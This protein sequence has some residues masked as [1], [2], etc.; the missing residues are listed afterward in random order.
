MAASSTRSIAQNPFLAAAPAD[1]STGGSYAMVQAGPAVDPAEVET[2]ELAVEILVKWSDTVLHVSHMS[3]ARSFTVG[4][5]GADLALPAA[6]NVS[7]TE[8]VNLVGGTPVAMVPAGVAAMIYSDAGAMNLDAA[9][10]AGLADANGCIKIARGL[11]VEFEFAG[12]TFEIGGVAAAKKVAGK[13]STDKRAFGAQALSFG[14]HAALVGSMFV[15]MPALASTEDNAQNDDQLYVLRAMMQEAEQARE[16]D[17]SEKLSGEMEQKGADQGSGAPSPGEAGMM[18][19]QT[20]PAKNKRFAMSTN[21]PERNLSRREALQDAENFGMVELLGMHAAAVNAGPTSPWGTSASGNDAVMANGNMWGEEIGEAGGSNG[22]HLSG[23]GEGGGGKFE[24]V[25][26]GN[27]STIFGGAGDCTSGP[28]NG[29]G[30]STGHIQAGHKV[31]SPKVRIASPN[32][33][34]RIPPEVIQRVVRQN[35]GRFRACYEIGLRN[36]PNLEGRVAVAFTIGRDGAVG[37]ASNAGSSLPD[38]GVV[39]CVASSFRGLSFPAPE[40]GIVTVTYPISF[41]PN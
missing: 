10:S 14:L 7:K 40:Q 22:L 32:V 4:E 19:S 37:G 25:G 11:R 26:V 35:F 28:C 17:Q 41:S 39:S 1:E 8:L 23:I 33:S 27:I 9:K 38:S 21:S 3:P 12:C 13:A 20:S 30:K 5:E 6:S 18:G 36:N 31:G 34:G 29:I 24:G 15:F 16:E 2:A